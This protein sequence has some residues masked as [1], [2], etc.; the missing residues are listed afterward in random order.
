MLLLG[1]AERPI[2]DLGARQVGDALTKHQL[3]VVMEVRLD[4]ITVE[5]TGDTRGLL[6]EAP[7]IRLAPP[8]AQTSIG[9]E[10]CALVVEAVTDLVPDHHAD[11]AVIHGV[12][13]V[14][15]KRRRLQDAG[16]EHD[17]VEE[18]IVIGIGGR[19]RVVPPSPIGRLADQRAV[20]AHI[21]LSRGEQVVPV[22]LPLDA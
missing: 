22:R 1:L 10:L 2:R 13:G 19:W 17:L 11:A 9:V 15:I 20:L 7:E 18:R 4:E 16:R 6:V 5:L 12:H 14:G 21:P 8:I 3:A